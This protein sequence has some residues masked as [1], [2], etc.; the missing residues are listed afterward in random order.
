MIAPGQDENAANKESADNYFEDT[1]VPVFNRSEFSFFNL[2]RGHV[3]ICLKANHFPVTEPLVDL[4]G[5]N[6]VLAVNL[7]TVDE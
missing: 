3:V 7:D 1:I 2:N 6:H 4:D 5:K